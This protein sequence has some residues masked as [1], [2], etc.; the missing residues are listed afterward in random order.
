[1]PRL[2]GAMVVRNAADIVRVTVLHHLALGLDAVLVTDNGSTDGTREALAALAADR[3]LT[4]RDRPGAYDQTRLMD[5]LLDAARADGADWVVP[6]D[7]DEFLV[8]PRGLPGVLAETE[9]EALEVPVVN[10]VQRRRVRRSSAR[11][12]LSMDHRPAAP[13]PRAE[14]QALVTAGERALVERPWEPTVIFRPRPGTG[15]AIGNHAV[16]GTDAPAVATDEITCLHAPLRSRA[17]LAYRREHAARLAA[18]R[19]DPELGWHVRAL[20]AALGESE[21]AVWRA[22]SNARGHLRVGGRRRPLVRDTRL[23]DAV[24][25]FV[26]E[27]G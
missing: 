9:A 1:M 27:A 23:R 20:A 16:T 18:V 21:R 13:P 3:P 8:C 12:L 5:E 10:F 11:A 22:N 19:D 2:V 26:R 25:P 7:V 6:F 24:A 15:L 14:A 17:Q 4:L